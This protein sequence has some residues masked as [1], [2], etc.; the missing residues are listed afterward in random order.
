[1]K[2]YNAFRTVFFFALDKDYGCRYS[3]D[4][5]KRYIGKRYSCAAVI[6]DRVL[7]VNVIGC[8]SRRI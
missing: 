5:G 3:N 8:L 7:L 1:M 2:A 4:I 6:T